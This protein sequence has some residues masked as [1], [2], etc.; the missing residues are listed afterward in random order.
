MSHKPS[1]TQL[2]QT[3]PWVL[4]ADSAHFC[5]IFTDRHDFKPGDRVYMAFPEG[6]THLFDADSGM[7]I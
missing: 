6:K 4:T 7:R 3:V 5:A 1:T 2:G